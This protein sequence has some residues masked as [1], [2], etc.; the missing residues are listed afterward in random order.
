MLFIL[1]IFRFDLELHM[2]HVT[3]DVNVKNKIA[4]VGLFYKIGQPDP[5]ISKV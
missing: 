4:V 2:V 3:K 1:I 5:F